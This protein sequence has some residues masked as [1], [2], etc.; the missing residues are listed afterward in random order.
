[1]ANVAARRFEMIGGGHSKFWQIGV[2]GRAIT[3]RFG[4]IGSGGVEKTTT[5]ATPREASDAVKKLVYEKTKKGYVER[6]HAPP[7][8]TLSALW[9]AKRPDLET[10]LRKG[11]SGAQ[12]A[13]FREK[14]GLP[15]P[16][17]FLAMYAWHD[18]AKDENEWFE[19]AYGFFRLAFI[20]SHKDIVDEVRG[21]DGTWDK[22]WV[23]FLQNNYSDLVCLDTKTGEVFEWF[24]NAGKNRVFLAPTFD[25]WLAQHVAI[26]KAAKSLEDDD[27]VYDA[28]TGARAKKVRATISP[29]HA[30]GRRS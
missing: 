24:N 6:K 10:G 22:A 27:A 13:T 12:L 16:K 3:V 4:R 14:L 19:G 5:F 23:P 30:K 9:S 28:F 15:L 18:G 21:D 1:M 29:G 7:K 26:T 2:K 20:L 8:A 11:A 17:A 25:A